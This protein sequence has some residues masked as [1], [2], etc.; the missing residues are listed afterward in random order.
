VGLVL[1]TNLYRET[2]N[3]SILDLATEKK[4]QNLP[5]GRGYVKVVRDPIRLPLAV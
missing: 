1:P 3:L 4:K 2:K 5:T